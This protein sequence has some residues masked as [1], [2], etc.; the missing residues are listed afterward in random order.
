MKG[1]DREGGEVRG[2]AIRYA[3]SGRPPAPGSRDERS[4]QRDRVIL[5][6]VRAGMTSSEI[7]AGLGVVRQN[8]NRRLR[9]LER[10]QREISRE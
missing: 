9:Q 7:A 5:A 3:R 10:L 8:V 4:L 6:S 2:P 1:V